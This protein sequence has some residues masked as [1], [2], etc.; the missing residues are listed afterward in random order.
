MI[1]TFSFVKRKKNKRK[2]L[3]KTNQNCGKNKESCTDRL[4][5]TLNSFMTYFTP[6]KYHN[7]SPVS[8]K[9]KFIKIFESKFYLNTDIFEHD[10]YISEFN[11]IHVLLNINVSL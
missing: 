1:R 9:I 8:S 7:V 11:I 5:R 2:Y 3:K 10:I 4:G 6:G